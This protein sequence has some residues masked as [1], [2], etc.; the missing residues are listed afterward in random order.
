MFCI[1]FL[2]NIIKL[3]LCYIIKKKENKNKR[4][5]MN[6][7]MMHSFIVNYEYY[8]FV[9]TIVFILKYEYHLLCTQIN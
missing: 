7:C 1:L 5:N 4:K 2:I 3:L 6:I 9:L 8:Q